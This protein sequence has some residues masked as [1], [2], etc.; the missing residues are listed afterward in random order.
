[1]D[2]THY[3]TVCPIDFDFQNV[4]SQVYT[5]IPHSEYSLLN[6][7]NKKLVPIDLYALFVDD[8]GN[9]FLALNSL[10]KTYDFI[11][12]YQGRERIVNY[13]PYE[14][15]KHLLDHTPDSTNGFFKFMDSKPAGRYSAERCDATRNGPAV[16]I[17]DGQVVTGTAV[18]S[19]RPMLLSDLEMYFPILSVDGVGH[20]IYVKYY[21]GQNDSNEEFETNESDLP[22]ATR[23]IF[24]LLKLLIEWE[25]MLV[26][27]WSS[28]EPLPIAIGEF[29]SKLELSQS[30][31]DDIRSNH[32]PMHIYRYLHND[33][34]ARR[35]PPANELSVLTNTT[36]LWLQSKMFYD[37]IGHMYRSMFPSTRR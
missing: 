22:S 2:I 13:V 37:N 26:N 35:Q 28:I 23:S 1:M 21:E 14:Q 33:Q 17:R 11:L 4:R 20:L 12:T 36:K 7:S 10:F 24:P 19:L 18:N 5:Q 6:T 34:N 32:G 31:R 27:P 29:F 3:S 9:L 25:E 15:T 8:R 30:V 16:F